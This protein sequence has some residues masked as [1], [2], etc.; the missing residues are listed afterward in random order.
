VL[1]LGKLKIFLKWNYLCNRVEGFTNVQIDDIELI[2]IIK[3]HL[4]ERI[5]VAEL[6]SG[7]VRRQTELG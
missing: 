4:I 2:V 7:S 5:R 1:P 3:I 6:L